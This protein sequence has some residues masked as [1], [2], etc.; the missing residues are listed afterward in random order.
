MRTAQ[1]VFF[2]SVHFSD[3]MNVNDE[4]METPQEY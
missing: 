1:A 3:M 4:V 2:C